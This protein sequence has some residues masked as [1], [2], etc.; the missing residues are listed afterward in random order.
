MCSGVESS[1]SG[2]QGKG[3]GSPL[4]MATGHLHRMSMEEGSSRSP[5]AEQLLGVRRLLSAPATTSEHL[6][7][8]PFLARHILSPCACLYPSV[9]NLYG[10]ILSSARHVGCVTYHAVLTH[11]A[12][13]P[14]EMDV[15]PSHTRRSHAG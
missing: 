8:H 11:A 13:M 4:R 5:M 2:L 6:M 1:M 15:V 9:P 7:R 12:S 10:G 3:M 14:A